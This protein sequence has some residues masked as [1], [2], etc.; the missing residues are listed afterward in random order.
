MKKTRKK[1]KLSESDDKDPDKNGD[2]KEDDDNEMETEGDINVCMYYNKHFVYHKL[3]IIYKLHVCRF[4][5]DKFCN[6][7]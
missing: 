4:C 2:N 3:C 7:R 6:K 5:L 1:T